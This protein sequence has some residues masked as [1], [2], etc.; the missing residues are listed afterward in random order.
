MSKSGGNL[1]ESNDKPI[2]ATYFF[3]AQ[4]QKLPRSLEGLLRSI[5]HQIL[6]QA[7]QL[8]AKVFPS[9][10]NVDQFRETF[11]PWS[12]WQLETVLQD[13]LEAARTTSF[14]IFVDGLDECWDD[15]SVVARCIRSF[16]DRAPPNLKM[17][18]ASRPYADFEFEFKKFPRLQVEN[19][20][21][22]DIRLHVDRIFEEA[23]AVLGSQCTPL[24]QKVIEKARGIFIWVTLVCKSLQR[25]WRRYEDIKSLELRLQEMPQ[26]LV[27]LYQRIL[28]EMDPKEQEEAKKLLII[29][30][31]AK[32]TMFLP[33]LLQAYLHSDACM[34]AK[35]PD[36]H[37]WPLSLKTSTSGNLHVQQ[38]TLQRFEGRVKAICRGLV[39]VDA[40]WGPTSG[41]LL[42]HETVHSFVRQRILSNT[43]NV[44]QLNGSVLLLRACVHYLFSLFSSTE[45]YKWDV[46][47][48]RPE[49]WSEEHTDI[50]ELGS[51]LLN[52]RDYIEETQRYGW[53]TLHDYP[54]K[55]GLL[56]Y[57]VENWLGHALDAELETGSSHDSIVGR[58]RGRYFDLWRRLFQIHNPARARRMPTDPLAMAVE[59]GLERY[60]ESQIK[61]LPSPS[62]LEATDTSQMRSYANY[63]LFA[64]AKQGNTTLADILFKKG[65]SLNP[66][67]GAFWRVRFLPPDAR[68]MVPRAE[69]GSLR[70]WGQG[71]FARA[72]HFDHVE[73]VELFMARGAMMKMETLVTM[74]LPW[75]QTGGVVRMRILAEPAMF[76]DANSNSLR[77]S[78]LTV[79]D[80]KA[81]SRTDDSPGGGKLSSAPILAHIE[82][83][84][85]DQSYYETYEIPN[86]PPTYGHYKAISHAVQRRSFRV[87]TKLLST[88]T[89]ANIQHDLDLALIQ[90]AELGVEQC[91]TVLLKFGADAKFSSV[92]NCSR[93]RSGCYAL[94]A[95]IGR[96][97][98]GIVSALLRAGSDPNL[99]SS[100]CQKRP[101]DLALE[102]LHRYPRNSMVQAVIFQV[103]QYGGQLPND[104]LR[105]KSISP[106]PALA[107]WI[108]DNL[109]V[110]AEVLR[111]RTSPRLNQNGSATFPTRSFSF[112]LSR[113]GDT[114]ETTVGL[115]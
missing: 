19:H 59:F 101:I 66:R 102:R 103:V 7:P 92:E 81:F 109:V 86:V 75:L 14:L 110:D 80:A 82:K 41:V 62:D 23:K 74:S 18:V 8:I 3:D 6:L 34:R 72:V 90:A 47:F 89:T 98:V 64:V 57:S 43:T 32:R 108:A 70:H 53:N 54:L 95:A 52:H 88:P 94:L 104:P 11:L 97:D 78:R 106:E 96:D 100:C 77:R 71:A 63:L 31:L 29:V 45:E 4:A 65:A 111:N 33:E 114:E 9:V 26:D 58:L 93:G 68:T 73:L 79:K 76:T 51:V 35:D 50:F 20:T 55:L 107:A 21:T 87:L 10:G 113:D 27:D 112:D 25:G 115:E 38:E 49:K 84:H 24:A 91:V 40:P 2:L 12:Q 22:E 44:S 56:H 61:S 69:I 28:D 39:Q 99:L 15:S 60:A 16:A 5:I 85:R 37:P 46:R 48:E 42:L 36:D 105:R 1:S 17:C 83:C 67:Q 30:T 13:V